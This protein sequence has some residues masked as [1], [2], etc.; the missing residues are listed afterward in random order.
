MRWS[1]LLLFLASSPILFSQEIKKKYLGS[2]SGELSSYALEVGSEVYEVQAATIEIRLD[3]DGIVVEKI[4][5]KEQKGTYSFLKEDKYTVS[6]EV[7]LTSQFIPESYVLYKKEKRLERK[8][9]Y[10]QPDV[11]LKKN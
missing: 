4:A 9:I 6:L 8:G 11:F 3:P 5:G 2:Y 10:P 1:L 7:K